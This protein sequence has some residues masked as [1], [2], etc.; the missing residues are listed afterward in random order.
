MIR[1]IMFSVIM[2]VYNAAVYLDDAVNSILDQT[3]KNFELILVDDGSTDGSATKCDQ[4]ARQDHRIRVVHI[5]NSGISNARNV[6]MKMAK[7]DYLAFCDHDDEYSNVLMET[8]RQYVDTYDYPNVL[9]C[10]ARQIKVWGKRSVSQN[11]LPDRLITVREVVSDYILLLKFE[12]YI[13]DGFYK[14]SFIE[15]NML[16]FD[17]TIKKGGEDF[18]FNIELFEKADSI[19]SIGRCLYTHYYRVGQ[20]TSTKYDAS[21]FYVYIKIA[22]KEY[23]LLKSFD[24]EYRTFANVIIMHKARFVITIASDCIYKTGCSLN[25]QEIE[26]KIK[27][28]RGMIPTFKHQDSL[29]AFLYLFRKCFKW[30]V[31]YSFFSLHQIWLMYFIMR[32]NQLLRYKVRAI[33]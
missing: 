25:K 14:R 32:W 30:G 29:G 12:R 21:S 17:R 31:L 19:V 26:Y 23:L 4:F 6:G 33:Q 7:G 3:Y 13:W 22:Q 27:I 20:S 1:E 5:Q 9:K 16:F 8:V 10:T 15:K 24:L 18:Y 11:N 28:S 2:P